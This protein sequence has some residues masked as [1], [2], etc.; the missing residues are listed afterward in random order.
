MFKFLVPSE[1]H[2]RNVHIQ[3]CRD[4]EY[5]HVLQRTSTSETTPSHSNPKCDHIPL[6]V[7]FTI[8]I[9]NST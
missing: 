6:T 5:V 3:T 8:H 2:Y 7:I 4:F 1:A 9:H